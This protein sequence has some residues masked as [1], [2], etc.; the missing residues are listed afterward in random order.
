MKRKQSILLEHCLM[1]QLPVH[2][3]YIYERSAILDAPR[4]SFMLHIPNHNE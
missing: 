4:D 3:Q 2:P 1:N